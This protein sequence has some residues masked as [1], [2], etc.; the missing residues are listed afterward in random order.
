[1]ISLIYC[2][3]YYTLLFYYLRILTLK[4]IYFRLFE[5]AALRLNLQALTSFA[6]A[7]CEVSQS[8]LF[9]RHPL[10]PPGSTA[11]RKWW[12]PSRLKPWGP[13][14]A[15][16][17]LLLTRVGTVMLRTVRSGRPL[18][19]IMRVWSIVGPHLMEVT[20]NNQ[21]CSIT[22]LYIPINT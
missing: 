12:A 16:T 15:D 9:A 22:K 13:S 20:T 19:H 18:V 8:Q 14:D 17:S 7:L 4:H 1:M 21:P 3:A 2:I 11:P 5:E 6:R 10:G